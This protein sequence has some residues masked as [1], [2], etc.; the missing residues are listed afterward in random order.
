[1]AQILALS[2]VRWVGYPQRR[3]TI[4]RNIVTS[5]HQQYHPC[6]QNTAPAHMAD[7][8]SIDDARLLPRFRETARLHATQRQALRDAAATAADEGRATRSKPVP[9]PG[10]LRGIPVIGHGGASPGTQ[11][12]AETIRRD[13]RRRA[14]A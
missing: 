8:L 13:E 12:L 5:R 9:S 1:M 3:S 2:V 4:D 7:K 10:E 6:A 11:P 14:A